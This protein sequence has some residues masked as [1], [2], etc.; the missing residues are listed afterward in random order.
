MRT[1]PD[2]HNGL[3]TMYAETRVV[4]GT[5]AVFA[6]VGKRAVTRHFGWASYF[7]FRHDPINRT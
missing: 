3:A 6:N 4:V 1:G 5:A 2:E 7:G